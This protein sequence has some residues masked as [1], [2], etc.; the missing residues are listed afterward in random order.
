MNI[1]ITWLMFLI[2]LK[3]Y[4]M[5]RKMMDCMVQ[6]AVNGDVVSIDF[7]T[8]TRKLY[9]IVDFEDTQPNENVLVQL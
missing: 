1:D 5:T 9:A 8:K 3:I 4:F 6:S 2:N 7:E